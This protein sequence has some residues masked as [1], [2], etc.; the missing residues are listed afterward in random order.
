MS[1]LRRTADKAGLVDVIDA[2]LWAITPQ[3]I[4]VCPHCH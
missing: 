4:N 1:S 2:F 3:Y